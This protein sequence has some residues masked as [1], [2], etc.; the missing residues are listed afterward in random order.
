MGCQSELAQRE[1]GWSMAERVLQKRENEREAV[2]ETKFQA[3]CS[4]RV[5]CTQDESVASHCLQGLASG[6]GALPG[7]YKRKPKAS[8]CHPASCLALLGNQVSLQ[9][10]LLLSHCQAES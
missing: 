7:H 2:R 6:H 1:R 5:S 4:G 8:L 9:P 3:V 10:L